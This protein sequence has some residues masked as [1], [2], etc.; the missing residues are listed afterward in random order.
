VSGDGAVVRRIAAHFDTFFLRQYVRGKMASDPLYPA[1]AD[2]LRQHEHPLVDV[3][4]GV[5]LMAFYLR[6]A[7]IT[8][9]IA[10]IDHDAAKIEAGRKI[11]A[12]YAGI[13]LLAADARESLPAGHSVLLLDLLHYFTADIQR[14]LLTAAAEGVPPGGVVIVR[15]AVRD[16]SWRYR[17]T[18]AQETFARLIGWLKAERLEFPTRELVVEPF[19]DRGFAVEVT[20]LWGGTP[21]N[22]YLFVFRRSSEGMTKT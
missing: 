21:F 9:P 2:L 16:G 13:E 8:I 14:K 18:Y 19:Q 11:A 15:D 6:E 3:G 10:G 17:I 5:G 20:P 1:V 7:G 22:N 4:C 12:S